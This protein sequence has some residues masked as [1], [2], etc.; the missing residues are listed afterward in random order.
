MFRA[1]LFD[2]D[3]V[4]LDSEDLHYEAFRRVFEEEGVSLAR[5]TYYESCLGF[6]DVECFR[7]GLRGSGKIQEAGGMKKA[8]QRGTELAAKLDQ[9]LAKMKRKPVQTPRSRHR[10]RLNFTGATVNG[11]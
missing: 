4:I 9:G 7:W 5:E 6:N 3:G 10:P 1:I 8:I 11:P 2:F